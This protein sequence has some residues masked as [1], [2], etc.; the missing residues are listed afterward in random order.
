MQILVVE[1]EPRMAELLRRG[2][3]EEGHQ[4]VLARDGVAGFEI[5]CASAFDVILL[6][7]MLPGMDGIAVTRRLRERRNQTPIL[8]LTARDAAS[9]VVLGLDCGA[10]DYLTSCPDGHR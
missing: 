5:A 7:V 1:D 4:V 2:L 8:L 3:A 10:D 6:D 9:D